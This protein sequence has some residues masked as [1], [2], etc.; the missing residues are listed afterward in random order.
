MEKIKLVEKWLSDT[1]SGYGSGYG[2]GSGSGSGYGS[3]YDDG[4]GFGYGYGSGFGSGYGS[5]DGY[6]SG[7]GDGSGSG[8]GDGSGSKIKI[9]NYKNYKVFNVDFLPTVFCKIRGNVAKCRLIDFINFSSKEC[10]LVKDNGLF[11]H[12]DTLKEAKEA[13]EKKIYSKLNIY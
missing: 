13:L 11:A 4:S 10:Y 9:N 3:G 5:G 7:Y 12:R 6:G 8:S 2:D 1:G